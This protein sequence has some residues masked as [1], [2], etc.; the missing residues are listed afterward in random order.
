MSTTFVTRHQGAVTWAREEGLLGEDTRIVADYDPE[1][2]QPGEIVIGTL[3]AQLAARIC[4][5]GGRYRHLTLELRPELRG[6][7]LDDDS[8][9]LARYY[10]LMSAANRRRTS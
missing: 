9:I 4:E 1:T 6:K 8:P 5:R 10:A 3:P 2:A 7:E